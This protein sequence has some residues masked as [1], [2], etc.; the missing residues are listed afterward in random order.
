MS[1]LDGKPLLYGQLVQLQHVSTGKWLAG[2]REED[3]W[4]LRLEKEGTRRAYFKV[5]P[6]NTSRNEGDK[7]QKEM[8]PFYQV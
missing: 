6:S 8:P 1:Q 3:S 7:V 2:R 5:K 4:Q